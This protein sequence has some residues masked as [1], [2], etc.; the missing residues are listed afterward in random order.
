MSVGRIWDFFGLVSF[1][2]V[3]GPE[4]TRHF[5]NQS[6]LKLKPTST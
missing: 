6:D 4:N 2:D 5:L 3:I 1:H